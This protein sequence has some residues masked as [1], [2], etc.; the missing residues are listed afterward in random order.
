MAIDDW[1]RRRL[2]QTAQDCDLDSERTAL[3]TMAAELNMDILDCA[4]ALLRICRND[5]VVQQ[6]DAQQTIKKSSTGTFVSSV[7]MVRYR[8]EVGKKHL[9]S[10]EEI[11][12]ILVQESGVDKKMIGSVEMSYLYTLVELPDGMPGDIFQHLKTVE[13]KQHKLHIKRIGNVQGKKRNMPLK[14]GRHRS[15]RMKNSHTAEASK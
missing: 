10:K 11:K 3:K 5:S 9:I 4:A 14:R 7:K 8:L 12:N 15:P 6:N 2:L 1:M 13:I